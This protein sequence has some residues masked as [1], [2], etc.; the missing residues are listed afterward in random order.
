MVGGGHMYKKKTFE[1]ICVDYFVYIFMTV[2]LLITILPVFHIASKAFSA[3]WALISG[4]VYFWPKGFQIGTISYVLGSDLFLSSFR[5]SL[6]VT[7]CGTGLTVFVTSLAAYPLSKQQLPLRKL[8]MLM[9][10]FTMLFNGG[11]IPTYLL[12]R[13]LKLTNT[14][15]VLILPG[16]INVFNMLLIKNYFESIPESLDESARLDG[17]GNITVLFK[18]FLPLAAPVLAT[19]SLFAAVGFWNDYY[20]AMIYNTSVSVKTLPL[21]LRDIISDNVNDIASK[22]ADDQMNLLPEGIRAASIIAST[23]PILI[24]YPFL[25]RYFI[26]GVMIGSVKG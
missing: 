7:V 9:F 19:V 24:V 21:Y 2:Y 8:I 20:S 11:M 4:K 6:I 16:A 5:N 22:T 18:I 17:A 13:S 26:K 23:V 14:L 1:D 10:V 3:E 12:I 25:Q 15:R